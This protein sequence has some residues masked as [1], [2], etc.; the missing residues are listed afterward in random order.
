MRLRLEPFEY[1]SIPR[2]C[3]HLPSDGQIGKRL[4]VSKRPGKLVQVER[5]LLGR[6]KFHRFG[7]SAH[8]SANKL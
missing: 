3:S 7:V 2:V 6:K 8:C 1:R 5:A 4:K